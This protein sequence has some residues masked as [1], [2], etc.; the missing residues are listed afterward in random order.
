MEQEL[1]NA[2][3]LIAQLKVENENLKNEIWK[4]RENTCFAEE[5]IESLKMEL[6][7]LKNL[8]EENDEW[9]RQLEE[10]ELVPKENVLCSYDDV[11]DYIWNR[12]NNICRENIPP[13]FEVLFDGNDFIREFKGVSELMRRD[14]QAKED[15]AE[16]DDEEEKTD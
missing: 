5:A 9:N 10:C 7:E 4:E 1:T 14:A 2:K 8:K 12:V 13:Q 3:A 11:D 16:E 15:F 6:E